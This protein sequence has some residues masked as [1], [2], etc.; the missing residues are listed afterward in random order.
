MA[1][2]GYLAVFVFGLLLCSSSQAAALR[3]RVVTT[4]LPAY[5]FAANVAGNSAVVEN[6]LPG[7]VSLHDYQ[8]S[9]GDLRKLKAADLIVVNGLGME[10]FLDKVLAAT[11]PESAKKIVRL[12]AGLEAQLIEEQAQPHHHEHGH[13]RAHNPHIWL[14]PR[15]AM[16]GITNIC[17]ALESRDP[18]NANA[19]RQNADAY[20]QRLAALDAEVEQA[21]APVRQVPLVTYHNAFPY[22]VRRYGLKLAGVVELV[23]EVSPSPKELSRIHAVI[24]EQKVRALFAEPGAATRLARQIARDAGIKL[25]ELD[26]LETGVLGAKSY[27]E[28]MR[29][30]VGALLQALQP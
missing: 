2:F 1:R 28:I 26:P 5:C 30:N 6:L 9:P 8:L 24:R 19:Y 10:T 11:G 15:L 4:F 22:F 17:R 14:D 3:V 7:H 21:I 25:A 27:E 18:T 23:P 20:S 29:R 13:D 12:S 16:W